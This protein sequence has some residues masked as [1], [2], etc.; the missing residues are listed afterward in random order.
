MPGM[1]GFETCSQLKALDKTRDIPVMFMSARTD[2]FDKV[3]GFNLGG[4][5][6]ITKPIEIEELLSRVKTHLTIAYLQRELKKINAELEE[7]VSARTEDLHMSNLQLKE[8]I[9]ERRQA[10]RA[11]LKA[12]K[13]WERT[14]DTVP[15]LVAILDTNYRIV[16]VNKAMADRLGLTPAECVGQTC[17][18]AVH[19]MDEPPSFCPH[20]QLL[21]DGRE[22]MVEVREER[23]GGDFIVSTS[24]IFDSEGHLTGSVHVS[25]DITERKMLEDKLRQAY[26]M[27]AIGTLA[28]GIAH[29]F[30]NILAAIIGYAEILGERFQ[31]KSLEYEYLTQLLKAGGRARDLVKQILAFSR[32]SVHELKP[33]QIKFPIKEALKLIRASLPSTIEIQQDIQGDVTV[34]ADPTQ[35]HQVVMNLCTNAGHA[36]QENGGTLEVSLHDVE[37]GLGNGDLKSEIGLA[38][39]PYVKLSVSDTGCGMPSHIIN[40]IFDPFFTTKE[41]GVGTGMGLSVVH[42]IVESH[43]GGIYVRSEPGKGTTVDVF[44]P[45]IERRSDAETEIYKPIPGGL[46]NILYVDDEQMIVEIIDCALKSLGYHVVTR[47]SSLEALELFKKEP[48]RF[49]IVITDMTMPK[50]TGQRLAEKLI[51]I[52]PDIPVILITGFSTAIDEEKA[53]AAGLQAVIFKPILKR[54]LAET[55]RK[56]LDQKD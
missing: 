44:L 36:M 8:E 33:T 12:K 54:D 41:K 31:L 14:F 46:E 16:R 1:D 49:D 21:K 4:V 17:Y 42:G 2:T 20:A 7:R 34:L 15:D 27:E 13:D 29:D 56:V 22:H 53:S 6:Y 3:K 55:I 26:K 39:G 50:M 10:E 5:D 19:G 35:I 28:G 9:S 43:N 40:R 38:P 30:N 45:A 52:R 25:R 18:C 48:D 11:I 37:F 24:P 32:E 51:Q 23:L 47:T